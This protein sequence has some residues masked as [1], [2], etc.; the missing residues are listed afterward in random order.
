MR[1]LS[2]SEAKGS[3]LSMTKEETL[4]V[5]TAVTNDEGEGEQ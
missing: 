2:S 1:S 5:T 4:S 3:T